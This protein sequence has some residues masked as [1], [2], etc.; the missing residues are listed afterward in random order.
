MAPLLLLLLLVILAEAL[1]PDGIQRELA[2]GD[3][4]VVLVVGVFAA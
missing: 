2:A 4:R 3:V 1:V